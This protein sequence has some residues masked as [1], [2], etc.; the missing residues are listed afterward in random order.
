MGPARCRTLAS[1]E[2]RLPASSTTSFQSWGILWAVLASLGWLLP[3]HYPPWIAFHTDAWLAWSCAIG[4]AGLMFSCAARM[5]WHRLSVLAACL[6]AVPLLQL[7]GG[8][9]VFRGQAWVTTAYLLGFLLASLFGAYAEEVRPGQALNTLF[10]AIGLAATASVGLQLYQWLSLSGADLW[11]VPL[12]ETRP[13]GNLIQPNQMATFELW[14]LI[15]V[16]WG[17]QRRMLGPAVALLLALVL[18][19]GVALTQSRTGMA[20]ACLLLGMSICWRR[21]WPA[22][23]VAAGAAAALALYFLLCLLAIEPVSNA[24]M[25]DRPYSAFARGSPFNVRWEAYKLFLDAALQKPWF[26]YGW[27][28]L[29]PAHFA[30]AE[31]HPALGGVFQHSHNLFLDLVLWMG[32]PLGLTVSVALVTW[33]VLRIRHVASVENALLMMFL[34]VVAFHAMVELPL[35]YAYMLLPTGMVMGA[36]NTRS[37]AVVVARTSRA[38]VGAIWLGA[39]VLLAAITRDYMIIEADLLSLRFEKAF[40]MVPAN[41]PPKDVLV[42]SH[43]SEFI[44]IGRSSAS[45]G[46]SQQQLNKLRDGAN[47]FPSASNLYL[48]TA[49]LALNGREDEARLMIRKLEKT[50]PPETYQKMG[51]TWAAQSRTNEQ[52]QK[53]EWLGPASQ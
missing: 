49:A 18:L 5:P 27:T 40:N 21:L 3:N 51:R 47:A 32:V 29:A 48:Y 19:L 17:A 28:A 53:V 37:A 13:F 38:W 34:A 20:A 15:C 30:V 16:A 31:G 12:T 52:L 2:T 35:H 24:L 10:L 39:L 11:I 42:L 9:L 14:G 33:F 8:V 43:L 26:G 7:W 45:S 6:A 4:G 22:P 25:L 41:S 50:M 46:M 1:S 44:D 36:L 23:R